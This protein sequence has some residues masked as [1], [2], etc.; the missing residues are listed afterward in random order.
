MSDEEDN[1]TYVRP[2]KTINYGSLEQQEK[3]RLLSGS[4]GEAIQSAIA[5]GNI[6]I[7]EETMEIEEADGPDS[8]AAV[9]AFF[10]KRKR[11]RQIQVSTDDLEVKAN[12]RQ[13]GEPICLFGEGPADRRERLRALLADIGTD[14][15]K[16]E[17][18]A[19]KAQ[20]KPDDVTWY[21]EGTETLQDARMWI[22]KY[23]LPRARERLRK[24]REEKN[25]PEAKRQ[26]R[27][28]ELHK[29]LRSLTN[30]YSQI[31]D[32]RPISF[33]QFSPNSKMLVT[34]SWSGLCKLW[35]IPD[36][37]AI[38]TLR[39]HNCNVGA[40]VFHPEA[41]VNLDNRACCMAS[42][43]QDGTVKLWNLESEEPVADIEGH[44][45]YRVSRLAYHPSGRFLAT[46]CFDNSWRLWDLEA[47]EEILHQE[48]HSKPVYD[49]A[50]QGDGSLAATG[51]LDGFGRVWDLRTGRCI[52]FMEG[53]LKSVLGIDINPN[54]Y[55]IATGSEDNT[56][57]IWDI[58][59][60][61][62][63]YTIPSHTNLVSKVKFQPGN[64]RY[65]VTAS[66]DN[67]AKVWS[68]PSWSPLK[69]LAA[70]ESKV[71]CIDISPNMEYIATASYDRTFKVWAPD[72]L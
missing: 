7:S 58:R 65:L 27:T 72:I 28:Q 66:Y 12:L 50:F 42:C 56:C 63:V 10:E 3:L 69:T 51:G 5:A 62:L 45:P 32:N 21:H 48:G 68:H 9:L 60:R 35:S 44:A 40:I 36:C 18:E 23:S 8:N 16:K 67:T 39:G 1:V 33:C 24:A 64:G 37:S 2:K 13:L 15:I 46:C 22:A 34:A 25:T 71:M 43:A 31:G 14:A 54:G 19:E 49:I 20:D 41:T 4:S 57:K 53:H 17:V 26:A 55:H 6:N 61:C 11:A 29:K 47:Q 30:E 59:Q 70:H 38:R 52:M